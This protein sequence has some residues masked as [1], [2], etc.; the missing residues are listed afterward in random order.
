MQNLKNIEGNYNAH[1]NAFGQAFVSKKDCHM[2]YE[3]GYLNA[4]EY[5]LQQLGVDYK[6]DTAGY[7]TIEVERN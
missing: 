1:L 5:L 6:I 4:I 2:A 3:N 7:M